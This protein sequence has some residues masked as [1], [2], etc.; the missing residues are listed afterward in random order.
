MPTLIGKKKK[1]TFEV[2][3]PKRH[4]I[5][6]SVLPVLICQA[7]DRYGSTK[8]CIAFDSIA[9]KLNSVPMFK[10]C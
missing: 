6:V 4:F 2:D 5:S 10:G 3:E 1:K 9:L 8:H 7:A